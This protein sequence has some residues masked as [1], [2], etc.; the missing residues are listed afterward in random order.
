[1]NPLSFTVIGEPA[2]Q[3][4]PRAAFRGRHAG[5][6]MPRTADAWKTLVKLECAKVWDRHKFDGPLFVGMIFWMQRPKSHFRA[7]G[8]L[9]PA[10]EQ[11]YHTGRPDTDNLAKAVMDALTDLG[12]WSDD[13]QVYM[14]SVAKHYSSAAQDHI[15]GADIMI[16][17]R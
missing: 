6:Y 16:M 15:V 8:Q 17:P 9:K 2:A 5:I 13:S 3:P 11:A 12:V 1:M 4:R 10:A 14:L 7:N